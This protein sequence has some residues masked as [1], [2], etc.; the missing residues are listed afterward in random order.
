[1]PY[2]VTEP[3]PSVNPAK[4]SAYLG[5][6]RGGAGNISRYASATLTSGS[7]ATGPA[8]RML[9]LPPTSA[10][11]MTGRGG[12]GNARA[13][14]TSAAVVK[15]VIKTRSSSESSA[16]SS[17]SDMDSPSQRAMFSFDEELQRDQRMRDNAAR[18]PVYHIGRGG[19]GNAFPYGTERHY[20]AGEAAS[21]DSSDSAKRRSIASMM[22]RIS[23]TISRS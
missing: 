5:S 6:G 20:G 2:H 22:E 23:R 4:R 17:T 9:P 19:A 16:S 14:S 11:M 13:T 8:C 1:M 10:R 7:N 3:H 15:P 18:T 21:I 12:A